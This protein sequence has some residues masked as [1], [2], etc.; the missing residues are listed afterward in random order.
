[1]V[2]KGGD[3]EDEELGVLDDSDEDPTF[4]IVEGALL[5]LSKI[6]LK[7]SKSRSSK[8]GSESGDED[9][10]ESEEVVIPELDE[11][12]GRRFEIVENFIKDDQ[13]EK[14]KVDQSKIYLRK[15]GLRLTG[16]K[17]VL[18]GRI[19]E[20]LEIK[21]GGGEKKYPACSFVL[22]CKGDACTGDVVMFEQKVYEMYCIA[23][24]SATGPPCGTR[25][26]A[27]RI[28][29][30][31]YGAAKQQHT[32]TIEVLW[33]KG[34]KPLP[35]L[36][37][38]LIKGRN[39]YRLK[40]M[41]Q[42]WTDEE[43]RRKILQEK[44]ARGIIARSNRENRIQEKEMKNKGNLRRMKENKGSRIL[45][46]HKNKQQEN[47]VQKTVIQQSKFLEQLKLQHNRCSRDAQ[48]FTENFPNSYPVAKPPCGESEAHKN[49]AQKVIFQQPKFQ[50]SQQSQP[51]PGLIKSKDVEQT[52]QRYPEHYLNSYPVPKPHQGLEGHKNLVQ[53]TVVQRPKFQS[54][55]QS[56][57]H[58]GLIRSEIPEQRR[59]ELKSREHCVSKPYREE[60]EAYNHPY[61]WRPHVHSRHPQYHQLRWQNTYYSYGRQASES[62]NSF[63]RSPNSQYFSRE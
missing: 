17:E 9:D 63:H 33:S 62:F 34:E 12:D 11:K 23:S 59:S 58:P 35:P 8:K 14:L 54:S 42:R 44:H 37:P 47:P 60:A 41:R 43:Q 13:I 16:N 29:K 27:G 52:V 1:M 21:D 19:R 7:K 49:P 10:L 4:D 39:L 18:L 51:H 20:H 3:A 48:K 45:E 46:G 31:S 50:S 25:I 28:V 56:Q 26:V 38:L 32:F 53:N 2:F 55:Q 57:H 40:T 22:N 15:Y 61:P 30:E 5:A 6:S 36:H 24:R